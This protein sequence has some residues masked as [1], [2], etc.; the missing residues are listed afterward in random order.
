MKHLE[1]EQNKETDIWKHISTRL[2][3]LLAGAFFF[4]I[5]VPFLIDLIKKTGKLSG[6]FNAYS[7]FLTLNIVSLIGFICLLCW[8]AFMITESVRYMTKQ[9]TQFL[10]LNTLL[11]LVVLVGCF[12]FYSR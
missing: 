7:L 6:I 8:F 1:K 12:Y 4:S 2:G 11:I 9:K 10:Y 5:C 3:S